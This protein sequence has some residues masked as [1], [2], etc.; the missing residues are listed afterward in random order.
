M[1]C[2]NAQLIVLA[3]RA[4]YQHS[5]EASGGLVATRSASGVVN[6][7]EPLLRAGS[8]VWVGEG[9]GTADRAAIDA[10]DGVMI[11][12][13]AH[14]YRLRRVFLEPNERRGYYEGF[15]NSG[16]WPLCHRTAVEPTFY[17]ADFQHYER[18][19]RRF[20]DAVADEA[21]D[22]APTVLVQDYH[23][24][25]APRLIRQ[26]L[27]LARIASFWHIP[28]PSIDRF[29]ICPWGRCVLDGLLGSTLIGFQTD[30]DRHNFYDSARQVAHA[31]VNQV[32]HV[33]TYKGR[34]VQTGVYPASIEWPGH[35]A[36]GPSI[37]RCRSWVRQELELEDDGCLLG[38][39]VDRLD[40]TKGIEHKF[41]AIERFL[42]RRPWLVDRFAFVQL[43]EPTRSSLPVYQHTAGRVLQ[44]A[45]RINNRFR[46]PHGR[47]IFVRQGHHDPDTV[48]RFL[49][50]ADFCYVGSLHDGMN[51]VSKEFVSARDDEQGVLLLSA[52]AGAAC[53]LTDALQINPYDIDGCAS[54]IGDAIDMP[55]QEQRR[56]MHRMRA[57][58]ASANARQWA[59]RIIHDV[60]MQ[61]ELAA[62]PGL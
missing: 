41:L 25:L 16:L 62:A 33:I 2:N 40:Y 14:R 27:P 51:L 9:V 52:F 20:A 29:Q 47:P 18:V 5:H 36:E 37:A 54:A 34:E 53:E 12:T 7:V 58:V 17:A 4:P 32:A 23:F 31:T 60:G 44:M 50:G 6:A 11:Q 45:E 39:G 1:Q 28:W 26:Q 43:A 46:A 35:W 61:E 55:R 57:A 8:G 30:T 48:A 15:A 59:A 3:N 49:R 13:D 21:L 19:N 38:I 56:R 42:D 10:R 22:A 24:A